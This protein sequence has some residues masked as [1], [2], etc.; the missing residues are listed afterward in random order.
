VGCR[1]QRSSQNPGWARKG[2][3]QCPVRI[4]YRGRERGLTI[5]WSRNNRYLLSASHDSTAI[6]WDL[7]YLT[8]LL[9]AHTPI[10]AKSGPS[11]ARL[12]TL[13]FDSPLSNAQFHP[14][15]SRI[16]LATLLGEVVLVDLR[17]GGGKWKLNH[18]IEAEVDEMEVDQAEDR[19]VKKV[20]TLTSAMWSP[21]G[22]RI[23]TG[24]NQGEI[25]IFDPL[26]RQV[27]CISPRRQD[28][29]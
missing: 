21:C 20:S 23:Y 22:S 4:I 3:H 28:L 15:N 13:R 17:K 18:E 9:P 29:S 26:T 12:Q 19:P 5:S 1:N 24:T 14:R 10:H 6:V 8:P 2:S 11:S 7:S 27:S 25:I 16:I